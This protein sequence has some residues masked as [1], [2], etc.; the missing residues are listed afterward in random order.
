MSLTT[1]RQSQLTSQKPT[2]LRY[3]VSNFMEGRMQWMRPVLTQHERLRRQARFAWWLHTI[4][5]LILLI[6]VIKLI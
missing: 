4:V 6:E 2:L 3:S 1:L 5:N